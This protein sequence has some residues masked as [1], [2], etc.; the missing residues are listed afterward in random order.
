[1]RSQMFRLAK[2]LAFVVVIAVVAGFFAANWQLAYRQGQKIDPP[3]WGVQTYSPP[4]W[5]ADIC[6]KRSSKNET[7]LIGQLDSVATLCTQ[8]START[9]PHVSLQLVVPSK[10]RR[11]RDLEDRRLRSLA[12]AAANSSGTSSSSSSGGSGSSSS[13]SGA[14]IPEKYGPFFDMIVESDLRSFGDKKTAY[15]F[16][17]TLLLDNMRYG[18]RSGDW[19]LEA[20]TRRGFQ[21]GDEIAVSIPLT[22]GARNHLENLRL[23][24][25]TSGKFLDRVSPMLIKL[26]NAQKI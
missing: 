13:S 11:L 4:Q 15:H 5:D 20:L 8:A 25:E 10:Q 24:K 14:S 3:D 6:A 16:L 17:H 9:W 22:P 26:D 21:T 19:S 12:R 1:M 18:Y 7:C 2:S 23:G